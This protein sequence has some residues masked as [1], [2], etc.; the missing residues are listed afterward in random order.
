MKELSFLKDVGIE[1]EGSRSAYI[2]TYSPFFKNIVYKEIEDVDVTVLVR[3]KISNDI[4]LITSGENQEKFLKKINENTPVF[5]KHIMPVMDA[6]IIQGDLDEDKE[7]LLKTSEK[8]SNLLENSKFAVQCRVVGGNL[9]YSAKDLEVYIGNSHYEKG[10]VPTFSDKQIINEDVFVISIL[11]ERNIFYMGFSKSKENLNFHSDEA[12]IRARAGKREISRAESKL[13]E[14][15]S[16]FEIGLDGHGNALDL[17]AAPGGWTK[18]L[19]DYGYK[20]Y[21]V[22]P[23]ELHPDL[24]GH[25]KVEH[26]KSK[27]QDLDLKE[28]LDLIVNYMNIDPYETAVIMDETA[29]L[30]KPGGFAIIT[31]KLPGSVQKSIQRGVEMLEK[32]YEVLKVRSLFH[33]RQEVTV[34][35]KKK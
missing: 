22:D 13:V 34:F 26:I 12:R 18:V 17:G 30:L 5:I 23:A 14:A 19:V 3:K 32:E 6:G 9:P 15:L 24:E 25:P 29:H 27:S 7:R 2:I 20:V 11:I 16:T 28:D 8:I 4:S 33:N 35:L 21:A 10:H 31:F 1:T